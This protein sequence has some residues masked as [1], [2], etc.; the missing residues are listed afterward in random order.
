M[1]VRRPSVGLT[2]ANGIDGGWKF[3]EAEKLGVEMLVRRGSGIQ[4]SA[5]SGDSA[6]G[7]ASKDTYNEKEGFQTL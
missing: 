2:C 5:G 1:K 6:T 3:G 7:D 4:S